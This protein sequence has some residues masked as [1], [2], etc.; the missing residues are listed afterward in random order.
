MC[1]LLTRQIAQGALDRFDDEPPLRLLPRFAQ[2]SEL[3]ADLRGQPEADLR[4]VLTR[5]PPSPAGGGP[6][7]PFV[8][9]LFEPPD[10][11]IN[12]CASNNFR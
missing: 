12:V 3:V 9:L 10:V 6:T 7:L 4:I 11:R 1:L 8:N 5:A 2:R